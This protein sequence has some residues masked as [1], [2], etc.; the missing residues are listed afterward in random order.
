MEEAAKLQDADADAD[1]DL[2]AQKQR[3]EPPM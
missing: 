1:D 3:T 2:T